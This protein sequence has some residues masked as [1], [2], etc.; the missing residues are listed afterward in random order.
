M[1]TRDDLLLCNFSS[2]M[3]TRTVAAD[4]ARLFPFPPAEAQEPRVSDVVRGDQLWVP[5]LPRGWCLIPTAL[6]RYVLLF[7]FER[8]EVRVIQ[9][10]QL[11]EDVD[12]G[13]NK[14]IR[15]SRGS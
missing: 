9:R 12:P 10:V 7:S 5:F 14:G 1:S 6:T 2:S 3:C 11:V 8:G 13:E 4:E 15:A